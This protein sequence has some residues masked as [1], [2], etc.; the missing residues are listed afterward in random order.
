M[1]PSRLPVRF[2]VPAAVALCAS[3]SDPPARGAAD[4]A[5]DAAVDATTD[6]AR[7]SEDAGVDAGWVPPP[8]CPPA[9]AAVTWPFAGI[10]AF[11]IARA[12]PDDPDSPVRADVLETS[13][14]AG[15]SSIRADLLWDRIEP[16]RGA[17][18]LS[19]SDTILADVE[20]RGLSLLGLLAYGTSWASARG[21]ARYPPDD[22]ADF[23]AFAGSVA[24]R[25]VG[26]IRQYEVWNEENV[27]LRFWP[28]EPDPAAYAA[29]LGSTA[30][31]LRDADPDA[32]V[33]YGGLF[34]PGI[35]ILDT[36][37]VPSA[38]SFLGDTLDADPSLGD[39]FDV[40][41]YHPYRYP[42][43]APEAAAEGR[44]RLE[45]SIASVRGV[46]S[47]H[48]IDR[49]IWIT[50][51]GWHTSPDA[52][53][54]GVTPEDQARFLVRGY[55]IAFG[56]G[57]E[58]VYWYTS[59][60]QDGWQSDQE[61]AFGWI[62]EDGTPKP[63]FYAHR[64][65]V[66][67]VGDAITVT[68]LRPEVC[69]RGEHVYRFDGPSGRTTVAWTPGGEPSETLLEASKLGAELVRWTGERAPLEPE[70]GLYRIEL[71]E[72]PVFLVER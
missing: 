52:L 53:M 56:A 44:E 49:P 66:D 8:V 48:G 38:A 36:V 50:E 28:P 55:V 60:D 24:A 2:S 58:R 12:L 14:E 45:D 41:A 35:S 51:V 68:D 59:R 10:E 42:F 3:C 4:A 22:P 6:A 16:E 72:D 17:F 19:G 64:L 67:L 30:D 13:A 37:V 15:V 40:L 32:I 57:V 11:G 54:R 31:A 29:L 25:Y 7:P 63:A 61:A 46:L 23:A 1:V 43:D 5:V 26:R 34:G 39:S 27:G 62:A 65:L 33:V 70:G 9:G 18:D 47:A 20:S 69:V 21:E 71:D